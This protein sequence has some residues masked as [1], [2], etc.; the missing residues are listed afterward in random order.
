MC[1]FFAQKGDETPL[2]SVTPSVQRLRLKQACAA[3]GLNEAFRWYSVRQGGATHAYR[4]SRNMPDVMERGRWSNMHTA[5][6]Y[7][8]QGLAELTSMALPPSLRAALLARARCLRPSM[9]L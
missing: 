3:L 7:I 9:S 8:T 2:S 4:A 6:I 1:G 5:R